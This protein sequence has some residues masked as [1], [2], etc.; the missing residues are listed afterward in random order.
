[1]RRPGG[2]TKP[3]LLCISPQPMCRVWSHV[4]ALVLHSWEMLDP[5]LPIQNPGDYPYKALLPPPD[6]N[7]IIHHRIKE[8]RSTLWMRR[9][10]RNRAANKQ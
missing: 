5:A 10:H 9:Q 4:G 7:E 8:R 1:L 6:I 2:S 3:H